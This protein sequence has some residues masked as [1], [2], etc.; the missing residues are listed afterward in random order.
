MVPTPAVNMG[1]T[2][3]PITGT[4]SKHTPSGVY[5]LSSQQGKASVEEECQPLTEHDVPPVGAGHILGEGAAIFT[6]MT[7]TM[8]AALDKQMALPDPIQKSVSSSLNNFHASGPIFSQS[9]IRQDMPDINASQ[10][11]TCPISTQGPKTIPISSTKGEDK[12]PDLYLP[13]A[14]NYRISGK[15]YGY[16]DSVSVDNNPMILVELT[17]LSYRYGP[18]IYAVDRVNGRFSRGS[19][20]ISERATI[21]PQYRGVPLAGMYG[22]VQ[23][24]CM[25]TLLGMTQM[26]TPLAK[27]TPVTQT[28]QIPIMIPNRMPPVRDILEQAFNEQARADY[29]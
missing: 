28:S 20:M 4:V 13:V 1:V 10:C 22:P 18:T 8:F 3:N 29:L 6:D 26:I 17:G 21:E 11:N 2:E 24:M 23:P 19:R 7:E 14:E 12:Y 15:F 16:M 9:K 27:S 25:S 5:S